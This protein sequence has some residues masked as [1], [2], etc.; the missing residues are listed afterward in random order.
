MGLLEVVSRFAGTADKA[1][2]P[3]RFWESSV[4]KIKIIGAGQLGSRHLQALRAVKTPLEIRVIDPSAAS[5]RTARDR[6]ETVPSGQTHKISF[7]TGFERSEDTDLAIVATNSNVRAQALDKLFEHGA[8]RMLVL[9]K[10]LF[11][12][13]E[14][15]A[16]VGQMLARQGA[17]AWV[18]C[19]MRVM[20]A[21]EQIR[22]ELGAGPVLY[23][24]CGSQFGLVTNAIHYIDHAVHLSG[25]HDFALDVTGL[26]TAPIPSKRAGFLELNGTLLAR[27]ADG[28]RCEVSCHPDGTAPVVVEIFTPEH[29]YVVRESEGKLWHAAQAS[30]WRWTERAA[31]IPYQSQLTTGVVEALIATGEC[32]LTPFAT[33]ARIHLQLLDPLAKCVPPGQACA[34]PFT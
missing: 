26:A 15:Y 17:R 10:L 12:Q 8:C 33:S 6:Y 32:G 23:R 30:Q 11:D 5:L 27:L 9:E 1:E 20:P 28:S 31:V 22:A 25:C 24:V 21:Y 13:R 18:N 7:S 14:D 4:F 16:R 3:S 34:Y 2:Q 29:R 19:P